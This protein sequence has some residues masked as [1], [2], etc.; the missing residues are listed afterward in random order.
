MGHPPRQRS[1]VSRPDPRKTVHDGVEGGSQIGRGAFP[2]NHHK[3]DE[4][5]ISSCGCHKGGV[6]LERGLF[7]G[8]DDLARAREIDKCG[9]DRAPG[10]GMEREREGF[11]E[12]GL[13]ELVDFVV[14]WGERDQPE[15]GGGDKLLDV[16]SEG[17]HRDREGVRHLVADA[18]L[19]AEGDVEGKPDDGP[20]LGEG[21]PHVWVGLLPGADGDGDGVADIDRRVRRRFSDERDRDVE[22]GGVSRERDK[23]GGGCDGGVG[24]DVDD[25]KVGDA[26]TDKV[27]DDGM[28]VAGPHGLWGGVF[29]A[30][31]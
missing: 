19:E 22:A 11:L 26:A 16:G 9:P 17:A 1:D 12:T 15:R 6:D 30:G 28:G 18:G 27:G 23:L 24:E 14:V 5:K 3:H 4:N 10:L 25:V 29:V 13:E 31:P 7:G 20:A 8:S 2:E 21:A